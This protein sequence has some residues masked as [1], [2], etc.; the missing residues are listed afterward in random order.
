M[1]KLK[2]TLEANLSHPI[3]QFITNDSKE[4]III[5]DD[6]LKII[7]FN[8]IAEDIF[9]Y[10][11]N[12]VINTLFDNF[13][14][15]SNMVN[16][17]SYHKEKVISTPITRNIHTLIHNKVQLTWTVFQV[18]ISDNLYFVLKADNLETKS[19]HDEIIRLETLVENMPCNVYWTDKNCTMVGCNRNVLSM[20]NITQENYIGKTYEELAELCHWPKGLAEKLKNDDLEVLRTGQPIFG[21]EDPPMP[22]ANNSVLNLLTSRVPLR[23]NTGEIVG[24]AGISVDISELKSAREK[25]EQANHAKTE[26]IANMSHDIRTPLTGVIGIASLLAEEAKTEK[27]QSSALM[28]HRSGEQLLNLLNGVLDVVSTDNMNEE[29]IHPETF[30]LR[31]SIQGLYDLLSPSIEAKGLELR[32]NIDSNIPQYIINDRIKIE[33]IV[34]NLIT[35][36]I[37][38]TNTGYVEL[39]IKLLAKKDKSIHL[40]FKINDTGVGIAKDQLHNVFDRF[41]RATPA[42]VVVYPGHGIG[43]YI[44][45]KFVRL[46]GGEVH[47]ESQL[48]NG[49]TFR[50]ALL[51]K[52]GKSSEAKPPIPKDIPT[53]IPSIK[54]PLPKEKL[55]LIPSLIHSNN[56]DGKPKLLLVEDEPIACHVAQ[57]FLETAGFSVTVAGEGETALK[58]AKKGNFELIVSDIGLPGMSGNEWTA[59]FRHWEWVSN[60]SSVPIVGLTAHATGKAKED[61]LAAGMNDVLS[62]PLNATIAKNLFQQFCEVEEQKLQIASITETKPSG[63]GL[64]LP[65]TEAELF[66]LENYPLFDEEDGLEKL[67]GNKATL[68][69]MLQMLIQKDLLNEVTL[70]N[71]A[72]KQCDWELI[73]KIAHKLKGGALYCGTKKMC[74]ACQY[75]ERYCLAGHTKLLEELF[76]QLMEVLHKTRQ[77][78]ITWLRNIN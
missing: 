22:D 36:A 38:F 12:T 23:N 59:A 31:A 53:T 8:P 67:G 66:Q 18:K 29:D 54:T 21:V 34:L 76:K 51:M 6:A 42:Y 7:L 1:D 49:T 64:D 58:F 57:T 15:Q 39:K 50:F 32:I 41:F 74:Y 3:L 72:H 4:V 5:L 10:S 68:I 9:N 43:L 56:S 30:D 25:A 45:K 44:V 27:D 2:G 63:L 13:C 77:Y 37:K 17:L 35:N 70:L 46:L 14:T 40:E 26:F 11:A 48:D 20:L 71:K 52:E 19:E 24:V 55:I 78:L 60:K 16:F 65:E 61:C 62:K 28:I 69:K 75:M 33:R 73:Q 47:V